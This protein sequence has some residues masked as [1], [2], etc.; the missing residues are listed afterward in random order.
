MGEHPN[1]SLVVRVP[2]GG[3]PK[4]V[5]EDLPRPSPGRGQVLVK[6][7]HVAQNPTDIQSFESNAFGDGAVLGCDYVGEVVELGDGV[8][9]LAKG[10]VVAGLIW[11]GEIKGLGGYSSYSIADEN[12]CFK[13]PVGLSREHAS[14]VPLAATTAW[15]ALFSK[16]SLGLDRSNAAGTGVLVWGGSSSVGL[17]TVQLASL[18]GFEVIA[19]CSPRHADLVRSYGAKHVFD[20]RDEKV[21]EKIQATVPN[22]KHVFDTIG[23][24]SS[25]TLSS[26]ATQKNSRL[27][28]VRPGKANTENVTA[29]TRVTDVLVWTA[30]LKDHRY[31]KFH[32]PASKH[33]HE[34]SR[35]LFENLPKWLSDGTIKPSEPKVYEGLKSVA[36]GFQEYRDR[37]ISAYK[38]VY[39]V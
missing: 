37:K 31:G 1:T 4:L 27:C 20:Y 2:E 18:Y 8:S 12:I 34:L 10:D 16:D 24:Q 5:L 13:L 26:Q 38:I 33:D 17:Y 32:W 19:T 35:E 6:L 25:S 28:T 7:S 21:I 36:D 15:L 3:S 30:F 39:R 23:N 11:G 14:T 29:D 22:L 9:R